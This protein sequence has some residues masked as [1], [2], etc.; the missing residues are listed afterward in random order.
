MPPRW[1]A[2]SWRLLVVAGLTEAGEHAQASLL[3]SNGLR[4]SEALGANI[5]TLGLK[6]GHWTITVVRTGGKSS[7]CPSPHAWPAPSTS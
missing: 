2:T 7:P 3:A 4:I 1:T 6:R 5:A